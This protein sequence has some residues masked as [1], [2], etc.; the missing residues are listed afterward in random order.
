M[1]QASGQLVQLAEI[2]EKIGCFYKV[3][4]KTVVVCTCPTLPHTHTHTCERTP[5]HTHKH[6]LF[7]RHAK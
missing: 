3:A 5:M 6:I 4:G 1:A 2:L 7:L